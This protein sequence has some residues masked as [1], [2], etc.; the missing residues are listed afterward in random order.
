MKKVVLL[1]LLTLGLFVSTS[2]NEQGVK[3]GVKGGLNVTDMYLNSKLLSESNCVGG[4][5]GPTIKF[6]LPVI[7]LGIDA[8]ALYDFREAKITDCAN[9]EKSVKQEQISIPVN[10]RYSIGLGSTA[11]AFLFAGP[12]WSIN[13]G[14]KDFEWTKGSSYSFKDSNF[15]VNA[16]LGITL[17]DHLQISANYNIAMGKTADVKA[18]KLLTDLPEKAKSRINSWQIAVAY[19]F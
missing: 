4:F 11:S 17:M 7:G 12:Q 18:R 9:Q 6:T 8:S 13:I 10:A 3:L 15:S 2:A 1:T 5:I 14:D 19:F 16:G